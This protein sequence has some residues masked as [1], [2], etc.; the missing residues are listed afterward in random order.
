MSPTSHDDNAPENPTGQLHSI[1][2][3]IN[4]CILLAFSI[5][6]QEEIK[7]YE[8]PSGGKQTKQS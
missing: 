8:T 7:K 5:R 1:Q 3:E 4:R 2:F 6:L